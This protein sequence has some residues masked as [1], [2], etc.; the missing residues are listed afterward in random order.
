M[1]S[2]QA[3]CLGETLRSVDGI[4]ETQLSSNFQWRGLAGF[5]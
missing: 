1:R 2:A 5:N 3:T 4:L